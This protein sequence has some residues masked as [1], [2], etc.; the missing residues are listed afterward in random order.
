MVAPTGNPKSP[1][2]KRWE[3]PRKSGI[4]IGEILNSRSGQFYGVSYQVAIPAKLTGDKRILKQFSE[5]DDAFEWAEEQFEGYQKN[6]YDFTRLSKDEY[7]EAVIAWEK[8]KAL[9]LSLLDAVNFAL[10]L[11]KPAGGQ[12]KIRAVIDEIIE[13]K[14]IRFERNDIREYSFNDFKLRAS[15]FAVEFG[16]REIASIASTELKQWL[17]SLGLS[18]R[19]IKNYRM[20]VGEVFKYALQKQY[21]TQN[22]LTAFS[23]E[24]NRLINGSS[25]PEEPEILTLA[26]TKKLIKLAT[27]NPDLELL[28]SVIIGLFCGV[29]NEELKRMEWSEVRLD[30]K[31]P[32]I[33]IPNTKAKKRR[34]RHIEIPQNAVE[35]LK[36]LKQKTGLVIP[37]KHK[38]DHEIRFTALL[39]KG[40]W[41]TKDKS[42]KQ[43]STWKKNAI[44]HSFGSY[45]YA[46]HGDAMKTA[47]LLGHKSNDDVLFSHYRALATKTKAQKYFGIIP[48]PN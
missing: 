21:I 2:L 9:N 14:R 11:I 1:K 48:E 16:D 20:I 7:K 35:W 4:R 36:P 43:T 40:G 37:Q 6:G 19:S 26:E 15:K 47:R 38:R 28:P 13:S 30:E 45:H 41:V 3:H 39:R 31:S 22:P 17:L 12:K 18:S 32:Y 29:R 42:G 10:P 24:E 44:R 34:I 25:N 8:V 46:L 5:K 33:A 27:E 23:D